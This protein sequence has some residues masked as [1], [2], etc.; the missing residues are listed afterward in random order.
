MFKCFLWR[1]VVKPEWDVLNQKI[2]VFP[3]QYLHIFQIKVNVI[4]P[5]H[6]TLFGISADTNIDDLK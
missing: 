1:L 5:Y 6:D 3:L 2:A 4:V